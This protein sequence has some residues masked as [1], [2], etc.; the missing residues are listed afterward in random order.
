MNPTGR[1][2][3]DSN[4]IWSALASNDPQ[5]PPQKKPRLYEIN[6][7]IIETVEHTAAPSLVDSDDE[8]ALIP[9]EDI[10]FS[11]SNNSTKKRK[12]EYLDEEIAKTPAQESGIQEVSH[13][14]TAHPK[15]EQAPFTPAF[16]AV[17]QK[18]A[19]SFLLDTQVF[20]VETAFLELASH[21]AKVVEL[22]DELVG[23]FWNRNPQALFLAYK[24][25]VPAYFANVAHQSKEE[26]KYLSLAGIRNLVHIGPRVVDDFRALNFLG[27]VHHYGFDK[28]LHAL[29][30]YTGTTVDLDTEISAKDDQEAISMA[31]ELIVAFGKKLGLQSKN[32]TELTA[33]EIAFQMPHRKLTLPL[34]GKPVHY[35]E[36]H[37]DRSNF[38][39]WTRE[40]HEL[41]NQLYFVNVPNFDLVLSSTL[42]LPYMVAELAWRA[43]AS[44][45]NVLPQEFL[46]DFFKNGLSDKCFNEKFRLFNEFYLKWIPKFDGTLTAEETA[47]QQLSSGAFGEYLKSQDPTAVIERKST[48]ASLCELF[49]KHGFSVDAITPDTFANNELN[50]C[51]EILQNEGLWEKSLYQTE[52]GSEYFLLNESTLKIFLKDGLYRYLKF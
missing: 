49:Y 3:Y 2:N 26:R 45:N 41:A 42:R 4:N 43:K 19:T 17:C 48:R 10:D 15:I 12:R 39:I 6:D 47:L 8:P 5:E 32:R 44:N 9:T 23:E 11:A 51:I 38:G 28:G 33:E 27:G 40:G 35:A 22:L 29:R 50:R 34:A 31:K 36:S 24:E 16:D 13:T 30:Y 7:P 37:Q 46:D 14:P 21:E 18:V 20:S 25:P 52:S 1:I